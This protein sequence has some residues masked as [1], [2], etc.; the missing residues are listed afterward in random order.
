MKNILIILISLSILTGCK[1]K[2]EYKPD[3]QIILPTTNADLELLLENTNVVNLSP[4]LPQLSADEYFIPNLQEWQA[5][6]SIVAK[7]SSI[8]QTDI[9]QGDNNALSDWNSLYK[10]VFFANNVLDILKQY[11]VSED[12]DKKRIKGWALF[13]RAYAFYEIVSTFSK[14]YS[15]NTASVDLG[16]PLKLN[17]NIDEIVQRSNLKQTYEQ[18]L[19][20]AIEA[21]DLLQIDI[22]QGYRNRPS[23]VAAYSLL[24]RIYLSMR[25]YGQ[26]EI[27][28]D[29]ALALYSKLTDFNTL[30]KTA[31]SAFTNDA[32]EVIY[33]SRIGADGS[34]L[35]SNFGTSYGID[36]KVIAL[37]NSSDLRL[38]IYFQKNTLGNFIIK[39]I[40]NLNRTGF[41]GLATDE[42]F[43][44][45][46]ECLARRNQTTLA[47][48]I[49]NQVLIKRWNKDIPFQNITAST[50]ALALA[51]VLIERRRAL[52]WRSL[53]W[54]DLKRLNL[55][56]KNILLT[57]KLDSETYQLEPS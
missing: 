3:S 14:G 11:S 24:A 16:I 47:L 27:Y 4:S 53:R 45:K 41:T 42:V 31:S 25:N 22:I 9:Y 34:Q 43:L 55:E 12:I 17:A 37:Y 13:V 54:T 35:T 44:I 7:N 48:D 20:D 29:K 51:E 23:K 26:S 38:S 30:N 52:I 36:P 15:E 5:V 32:E 33:F 39:P 18:I 57:R 10:E 50:P 46:A 28:A 1:D 6:A 56:G 49:L 19:T 8:W 21:G 40:N 2:L